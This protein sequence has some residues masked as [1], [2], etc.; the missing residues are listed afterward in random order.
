MT[1]AAG[2]IGSN[3]VL[4][5]LRCGQ[6]V[7]GI[8]NLSTGSIGNLEEVEREVG[9]AFW[10]N[11]TWLEG[12]ICDRE[13]CRRACAGVDVVLHQAALGSVPRS[14]A[15][16]DQTNHHNVTGFLSVLLEAKDA[17]V[18]RFVYASSSSVYGDHPGLPK[19]EDTVGECLS[20]YAV[21]KKVNEM[22]AA[23]FGRCYG[24]ECI[25]LRYFNVFGARQSPN[26]PYAAVIPKWIDAMLRGEP[27]LIHGDGETTRIS[28]MWERGAGEPAGG[29]GRR[30][31]WALNTVTTSAA[32]RTTL[33][34]ELYDML[35]IRLTGSV[36][37]WSMRAGLQ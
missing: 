20:P 11:F 34:N 28:V 16:P 36:R 27:V 33:L 13:L 3:L 8:D 37:I 17:G 35:R 24:I 18:P 21:S 10:S 5:L 25:G 32:G 9:A 29:D 31:R 6:R 23:V 4:D 14:I 2:F 12:D 30:I 1:G 19:V 22:Y 7:T 15:H 26:G